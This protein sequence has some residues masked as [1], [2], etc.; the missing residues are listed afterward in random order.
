MKKFEALLFLFLFTPFA[1]GAYIPKTT[2]QK[3]MANSDG[4]VI[5][6]DQS[7]VAVTAAQG[8]ATNLKAQAEAYQGGV[9]VSAGNPLQVSLANTA[10]NGTAINVTAAQGTASNLKAQVSIASGGVASGAIASGAL[11]AGSIAVGAITAG[12]TSIATTEDTAAAA[13]EHL[14]KFGIVRKDTPAS[15]GGSDGDYANLIASAEGGAWTAALA[16][17]TGGLSISNMTS[18]DSF[19]ALTN[20]AQVIKGS[21][22][23]LYGWYIYNPNSSA[24]YVNLYNTAAAGVT[25]GTTN[26]V[27]NFAIPATSGANVLNPL[28]ITFSTAMSASC[29]TTGGGNSAPATACEAMFFYK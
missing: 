3:T 19:T 27:M 4:V 9:A 16:T 17:T 5:A 1:F 6:S 8:T 10:A 29:T 28:G 2:G 18:G 20:G 12:D 23:Q 7:A 26:P 24:V 14:L 25:V 21:A 22:G 13:G 11:A 15:S